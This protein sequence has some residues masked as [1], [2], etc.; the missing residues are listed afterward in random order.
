MWPLMRKISLQASCTPQA[1]P[2]TANRLEPNSS[3]HGETCLLESPRP[4]RSRLWPSTAYA[5]RATRWER[6]GEEPPSFLPELAWRLLLS[7][8]LLHCSDFC[9]VQGCLSVR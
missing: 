7:C 9:R 1:W 8:D 6:C 2:H 5:R 4:S 3:P